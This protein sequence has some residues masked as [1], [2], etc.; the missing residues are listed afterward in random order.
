MEQQGEQ[1]ASRQ[2]AGSPEEAARKQGR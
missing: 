2:Q 1:A